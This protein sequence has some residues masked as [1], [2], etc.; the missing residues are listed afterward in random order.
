MLWCFFSLLL[1]SQKPTY[2]LLPFNRRLMTIVPDEPLQLQIS[3][4]TDDQ[5]QQDKIIRPSGDEPKMDLLKDCFIPM[6]S[7]NLLPGE[8]FVL[9]DHC[10]KLV[11]KYIKTKSYIF[12]LMHQKKDL[13]KDY[14]ISMISR[15]IYARKKFAT[16]DQYQNG[17]LSTSRHKP[18]DLC[19]DTSNME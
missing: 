9:A 14:F 4:Q 19:S 2:T 12:L 15:L 11:D 6:I 7:W 3:I 10:H 13:L 16:A 17:W 8:T 18:P 5:I 1:N